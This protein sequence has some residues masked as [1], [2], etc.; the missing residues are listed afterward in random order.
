MWTSTEI[1]VLACKLQEKS[2]RVQKNSQHMYT[3]A[4][5]MLKYAEQLEARERI[6]MSS[7]KLKNSEA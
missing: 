5:K 7:A 1:I 4:Q 6:E 3:S 2:Q